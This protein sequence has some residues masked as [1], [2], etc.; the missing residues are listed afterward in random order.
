[1]SKAAPKMPTSRGSRAS[2]NPGMPSV[3]LKTA[4]SASS[5]PAV[6]AEQVAA[7]L[8]QIIQLLESCG[9]VRPG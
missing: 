1:M 7:A 4:M 5:A 8:L 2:L 3:N 9:V 6:Q